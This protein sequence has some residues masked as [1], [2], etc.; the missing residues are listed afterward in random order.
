MTDE[1]Q[2]CYVALRRA[3]LHFDAELERLQELRAAVQHVL[4]AI[5]RMTDALDDDESGPNE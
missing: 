4:I 3:M 5:E 2:P 1:Q